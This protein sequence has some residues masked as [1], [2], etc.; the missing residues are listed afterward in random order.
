MLQPLQPYTRHRGPTQGCASIGSYSNTRTN[1]AGTVGDPWKVSSTVVDT[2]T[3]YDY[4][5]IEMHDVVT[6]H[7]EKLRSKG[8]IV[9]NPMEQSQTNWNRG[10]AAYEVH[11]IN[12]YGTSPNYYY[13]GYQIVGTNLIGDTYSSNDWYYPSVPAINDS[14]VAEAITAAWAKVS[15]ND[16]E[17]L[18]Q[19]AEF[20][21][22]VSSL[23]TIFKHVMRIINNVR[24][25]RIKELAGEISP[26]E[27][28]QRYMECRYALRPLMYDVKG[29]IDAVY[30]G[31]P[32]TRQT[33][34]EFRSEIAHATESNVVLLY[35]SGNFQIRGSTDAT[36]SLEVRSGVLTQLEH[37]Q[38]LATWGVLEP[39]QSAWELVPFSFI[40][41]WFWNVGKIIA[42]WAPK[43][44]FKA[45]ASWVVVEDITTLTSTAETAEDLTS[46]SYIKTYSR[47]GQYSKVI[48]NKYRLPHPDRPILPHFDLNIN[49][50][51]T[52]DLGIILTGIYKGSFQ[53]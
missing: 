52:L 11:R 19:I 1:Y 4:S 27:V 51:K 28:A 3:G 25:L 37:L 10:I 36:R 23:V 22:T 33:F 2:G 6:E 38:S 29:T 42:S 14:I 43:I 15:A 17:V 16:A 24:K 7:W 49:M 8:I 39:F 30:G 53:R 18:V 45:L 44:G 26:K 32:I 34:R 12:R 20:H 50:W 47:T 13:S 46:Y 41:D 5:V 21:K 48:R 40:I 9:N 31:R 35:S